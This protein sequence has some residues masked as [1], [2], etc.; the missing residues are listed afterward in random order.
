MFAHCPEQE[1]QIGG[2]GMVGVGLTSEQLKQLQRFDPLVVPSRDT[3]FD[4]LRDSRTE[5]MIRLANEDCVGFFTARFVKCKSNREG[6][7]EVKIPNICCAVL[8][9]VFLNLT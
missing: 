7:I 4:C 9:S 6:A 2:A 5:D 8:F 1:P 3:D